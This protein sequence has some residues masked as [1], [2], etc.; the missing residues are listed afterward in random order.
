M[1]TGPQQVVKLLEH[2]ITIWP[3][4]L[5]RYTEVVVL[6]PMYGNWQELVHPLGGTYYYHKTKN[7]LTT[8][9][10]KHYLDLHSLKYFID[11]SQAAA[12]ED[13]WTLVILP[14]IFMEEER[15]QY[16]YVVS[17]KQFIAW[18][19]DLNGELLFSIQPSK[20]RHKI[21]NGKPTNCAGHH[22]F[23]NH[24][25]Q[26]EACLIQNHAVK[27]KHRSCKLLVFMVNAAAMMIYSILNGVEVN[28]FFNDFSS[29]AKSQITLAGVSMA[30]DITILA[31]PDL[32]MMVYLCGHNGAALWQEN[33][34]YYLQQKIKMFIVIMGVM[35][36]FCVLRITGSVTGSILGFLSGVATDFKPSAPLM[37]VSLTMLSVVQYIL[38][39]AES[40]NQTDECR[41]QVGNEGIANSVIGRAR[42]AVDKR[43]C[44]CWTTAG[45]KWTVGAWVQKWSRLYDDML[46]GREV[47][48]NQ[49]GTCCMSLYKQSVID[50]MSDGDEQTSKETS[51]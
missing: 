37:I 14:M 13:G 30:M 34:S 3:T 45:V 40:L 7:A 10:L 33:E 18:L 6:L 50:K 23:L 15:F 31:I 17:N 44:H 43:Q 27:E 9:N 19:E 46:G 28:S 5:P 32:G 38:G 47:R 25:N 21:P 20:W 51:M 24:H 29:Q 36:S 11:A 41:V 48:W 2:G 1:A 26:P 39:Y 12:N 49:D 16:Y 4:Q 22:Q 42:M 8:T 35:T